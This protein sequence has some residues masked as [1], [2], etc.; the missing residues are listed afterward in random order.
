LRLVDPQRLRAQSRAALERWSVRFASVDQPAG[1][2]SGG[3]A[4][5]TIFAREID[6]T[7]SIIVAAQPTRGLD[8]EA[9]A[10]VWAAL[11]GARDRGCGVLVISSDLDEL[12]DVCDRIVVVLSGRVVGE[13]RPPYDLGAIGAAMTGAQADAPVGAA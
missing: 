8:I 9:M 4:Q 6:D 12:F 13:F 11:R 3:N 7:A 2:L 1:A 5:K 10:F